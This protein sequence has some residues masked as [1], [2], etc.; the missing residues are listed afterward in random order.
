MTNG[1]TGGQYSLFRALFGLYLTVHF[2]A[3]LPWGSEVFS[4]HGVIPNA[5]SSP[6]VH[7]FPNVLALWDAPAVVTALLA[8]AVAFSVLFAVGWWDRAAAL[9]LWYALACLFGRN[10]LT[11]N[12]SLPFVG[13]LLL[14][15]VLLPPAPFGSWAGRGAP[16]ARA[17]WRMPPT[18]FG[19]AWVLM[20]VGYSYSGYTK[21]V[22][23]SWLDGTALARVL[24]NPLARP[25][26][27]REM[28]LRLPDRVLALATWGGLALELGFAPLA[29]V[30]ALR[31]WLWLAMLGM[32]L[33]LLSLVDFADLSLG[34][35]VL[36]LFT[37]DPRWLSARPGATATIFYDGHCGLC[38]RVVRFVLSED[39]AGAFRFAPLD[40]AAF[41]AEVPVGRR[42]GL[43]DSMIV[44]TA[45]GRFLARAA[46]VGHVLR[47]LGGA[48]VALG[49]MV[50]LV[51][52]ALADRAYDA[53][54]G[55]R[56]RLFRAPVEACPVMPAE[57]RSRFDT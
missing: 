52:A 18:I 33:G 42:A 36:H 8:V 1:W 24:D 34:M 29:L 48:W 15:H 39:R 6:F 13:W 47:R 45:D 49:W 5:G 54:A 7:L 46:A 53:V 21:L 31:P 26:W 40:S 57:L 3:L 4:S 11:A 10:P 9:G 43:P 27:L 55:V 16:D 2:V 35:V 41:A 14:A 22:S 19:A 25:S 44:R 17:G 50:T 56:R 38:H 23:A 20:A 12:P 51:P 37:F 28:F 30:G 32:H